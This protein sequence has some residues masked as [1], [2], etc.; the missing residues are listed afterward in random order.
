METQHSS[1]SNI[2]EQGYK[3]AYELACEQVAGMDIEELCSKTGAQYVDF[4][5]IAID[6]LNQLYLVTFPD[7]EILL[8]D[9]EKEVPLKDKILILHYLTSAKGTSASNKLITFKQLPGCASYFPVFSQIALEPC[10]DHFGEE[11]E[12]L[13]NAAAMLGGHKGGYG[14]VSVII[15]AFPRVPITIALWQGDD[16]FPSRGSIMFDSNISDY[17]PTEDIRDI[18]GII[19]RK[20]VKNISSL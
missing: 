9:S 19:A 5:K 3:L 13:I 18:C 2:R 11:P 4:S 12:Q 8:K 17:L 1:P 20:L 6:Y 15:N 16:E 10:L 14:D 7:I